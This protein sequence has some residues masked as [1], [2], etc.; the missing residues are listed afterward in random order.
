MATTSIAHS[1]NFDHK[2]LGGYPSA[3]TFG[4]TGA[5]ADGDVESSTHSHLGGGPVLEEDTYGAETV[6]YADDIG[7]ADGLAGAEGECLNAD[8]QATDY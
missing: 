1:D 2:Q 8:S 4:P 7:G 5:P 3:A 6:A